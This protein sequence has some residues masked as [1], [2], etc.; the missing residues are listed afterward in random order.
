[1]TSH[2]RI[3]KLEALLARV[4]RHRRAPRAP[5]AR[6]AAPQVIDALA[7]KVADRKSVV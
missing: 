1:M 5:S 2:E 7:S 4:Q 6:A 3:Q